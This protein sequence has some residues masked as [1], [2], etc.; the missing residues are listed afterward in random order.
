MIHKAIGFMP[1]MKAESMT[2]MIEKSPCLVNGTNPGWHNGVYCV[3]NGQLHQTELSDKAG[4]LNCMHDQQ[5]VMTNKTVRRLT[6][7]EAERLMG[8]PDYW[9]DVE[10]N[11]KPAP[12]S[13]RYKAIGNGM[14]VPCSDFILKRIVEVADN[15]K[16]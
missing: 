7:L 9:T 2:P 4:A 12:D 14:A 3:G 6:P 16:S 10:I 13:K 8:L 15:G 1:Q 5:A 11:G